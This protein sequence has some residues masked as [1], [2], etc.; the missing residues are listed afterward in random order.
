MSI[1]TGEPRPEKVAAINE[2][3]DMLADTSAVILTDY[4]GL[5]VKS[6]SD[7]RK[8]LHEAGAQYK[9]IKNNLYILAVKDTVN[10]PLGENLAGPTGII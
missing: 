4:Q 9:V 7:F 5:D 8:K 1:R 10:A 2:I 6:I 3:K